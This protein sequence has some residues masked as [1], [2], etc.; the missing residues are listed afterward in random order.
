MCRMLEQR[1]GSVINRELHARRGEI[2]FVA[3]YIEVKRVLIYVCAH[4][5]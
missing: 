3:L 4:W 2:Y 5:G 1:R